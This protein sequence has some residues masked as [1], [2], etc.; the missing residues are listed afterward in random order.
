MMAAISLLQSCRS[1]TDLFFKINNW[2]SWKGREKN[3]LQNDNQ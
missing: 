3:A 2:A 1:A